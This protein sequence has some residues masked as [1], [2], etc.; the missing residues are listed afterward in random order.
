MHAMKRIALVH[1]EFQSEGL[2]AALHVNGRTD[3]DFRRWTD[4]VGERP[5]ITHLAY[6]FTT[7]TGWAG[8][9]QQH[10][11]WLY[12]L[13]TAV[14]RPLQLLLRGGIEVASTLANSF[15]RVTVLDTTSF[16]KTMMRKRAYLNGRLSWVQAPTEVG[17]PVDA[18][19]AENLKTV[20][21]WI[22][23]ALDTKGAAVTH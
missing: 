10:A 2:P 11:A 23:K 14:K 22:G 8:R 17:A 20:Q 6:E 18:L 13:A 4:F 9:Q 21:T 5:E 3:A 16:F 19:F 15:E 12:G 1:S 7:G